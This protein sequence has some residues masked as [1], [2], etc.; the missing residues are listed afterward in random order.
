MDIRKI[1]T[2][3]TYD[4]IKEWIETYENSGR[5][6]VRIGSREADHWKIEKFRAKL[7]MTGSDMV[8]GE[9]GS[10]TD[11][12]TC[13]TIKIPDFI[14]DIRRGAF[15]KLYLSGAKDIEI[16]GGRNLESIDSMIAQLYMN[17][18]L[19][20]LKISS[21]IMLYDILLST[22]EALGHNGIDLTI[23]ADS[24]SLLYVR[25][26]FDG[27][28][29]EEWFTFEERIGL[30][31]TLTINEGSMHAMFKRY[32]EYLSVALYS[33]HDE[34]CWLKDTRKAE[35]AVIIEKDMKKQIL[36]EIS[37]GIEK[38]LGITVNAAACSD[39]NT[40]ILVDTESI[41]YAGDLFTKL[42]SGEERVREYLRKVCGSFGES[43]IDSIDEIIGQYLMARRAAVIGYIQFYAVNR[44]R[45][46]IACK[47]RVSY[48]PDSRQAY[49][50]LSSLS[51]AHSRNVSDA[52]QIKF[53]RNFKLTAKHR[54]VT[55]SKFITDIRGVSM[56][57]RVKHLKNY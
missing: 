49:L 45:D 24:I 28:V 39:N 36:K 51:D 11:I 43:L 42:F 31:E 8:I 3:V 9:D 46:R 35:Q 4:D 26:L 56:Y 52:L 44:N 20:K 30:G 18:R 2:D 21:D 47:Y 34:I 53:E 14:T 48:M 1:E 33:R 55:Y 12:G 6:F 5:L 50:T 37:D 25:L 15:E 23:D 19:S 54:Y 16:T 13:K 10:I 41:C 29:E 32:C 17:N 27:I 38:E 40:R 22:T 57:T 7:K